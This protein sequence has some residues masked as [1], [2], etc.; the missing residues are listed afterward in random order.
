[1]ISKKIK[2]QILP[3]AKALQ[4]KAQNFLRY[5][6]EDT[7]AIAMAMK[8]KAATGCNSTITKGDFKIKVTSYGVELSVLGCGAGIANPAEYRAEGP[9]WFI[10][11]LTEKG[12]PEGL[13]KEDLESAYKDLLL[14]MFPE[15]VEDPAE[16]NLR[17]NGGHYDHLS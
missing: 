3:K 6:S 16:Y 8:R 2:N 15:L 10:H 1:M 4:E 9:H 13:L 12:V 14:S 11:I 7:D 5:V 17:Y